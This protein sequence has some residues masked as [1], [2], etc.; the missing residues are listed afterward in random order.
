MKMLLAFTENIN[1]TFRFG[2]IPGRAPEEIPPI[3]EP[4]TSPPSQPDIPPIK[5][6]PQQPPSPSSS[7]TRSF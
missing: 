1:L 5:E 4:P 7:H 2:E 6:P 3:K